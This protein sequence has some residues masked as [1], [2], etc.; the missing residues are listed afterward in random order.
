M[1]L[2]YRG[3]S[4]EYNPSQQTKQPFQPVI[5]P[6]KV[7]NLMYRGVTYRVD[8]NAKSPQFPAS[9]AAYK[10]I[11]RGLSY[12]INGTAQGKVTIASQVASTSKA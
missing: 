11:Y 10:L 5:Q 12:L 7:Y 4:Y 3:L 1:K 8:G 9:L 6:G 2:H